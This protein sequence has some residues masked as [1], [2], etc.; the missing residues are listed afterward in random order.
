GHTPTWPTNTTTHT[1]LPTYPFQHHT[2]WLHHT[3][4]TEQTE[5]SDLGE[6][7]FWD[8]VEREDAEILSRTLGLVDSDGG[9]ALGTALPAL[10]QW[11][12]RQRELSAV[13][14]L[15][16]GV[17]W[18][19]ASAGDTSGLRGA[20]L[21]V[22]P[23][24]LPDPEV[25]TALAQVLTQGGAVVRLVTVQPH[26]EAFGPV[27]DALHDGARPAGILSL[28]ALDERPD[29]YHG[30][31]TSGTVATIGLVRV[32]AEHSVPAPLWC[33]TSGAVATGRSDPL[34]SDA[35]AQVWGLG[36]AVALEGPI[37][38]GGLVD[39]PERL[40]VRTLQRLTAVLANAGD[41]AE[42]GS[43]ETPTQGGHR[44]GGEDQIALR[45][46]GLFVRRLVRRPAAER[47]V[48]GGTPGW[49][50]RGTVL[51]TGGTG[52][53]GGHVAR[54]LAALGAEH[55]LLVGRRGAEA[56]GAEA[57]RDELVAIGAKVTVTACDVA[58]RAEVERLLDS[59]PAE[60]PLT[61]V[62]HTAGVGQLNPLLDTSDDEFAEV[63]RAKVAGALHLDELTHGCALDAFVLFSS[64]SGVWGTGGQA[65]Y[66]AANAQLDALAQR[67]RSR[68]LVATSVAWGPW[69]DAGMALGEAGE[70]SRRRG[71]LPLRPEL[72]LACLEQAITETSDT[73]LTVADVVWETF[74]TT[75]VSV[76]PSPFLSSIAE[77]PDV[78]D[79]AGASAVSDSTDTM[80]GQAL[81]R[82][83]GAL[84]PGERR[85]WLLAEVTR[86]VAAV[87]G[88]TGS[89]EVDADRPFKALGFDSLTAVELRGRLSAAL[90]VPL[91]A[92]MVFDHP[93]PDRLVAHLADTFT[94]DGSAMDAS[95]AL[96][97]GPG[98]DTDPI[99]VVSMSCRFP[100]SVRGP[101]DLWELVRAGRDT[102]GDFPS[103][104]GWNLDA[105]LESA[106]DTAGSSFATSGSFL[107]DAADFD[108]EFFG[109]S[110]RE[111]L[112][113][114]PQ[115]RLLLETSWEA[116]ERA[117]IDPSS[118][119][120][121]RTG[122]FVG[123]NGQDYVSLLSGDDAGAR[124]TEGYRLTG[125]TTS[126]VSGRISYTFGLEGPAV[127]VDTACSSSLVALHL[128]T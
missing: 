44:C 84:P 25:S 79:T 122:V 51:I 11:R 74:Y 40:D 58:D 78:G 81:R 61:A 103:D 116:F 67:R 60:V 54:R 99:A 24:E 5:I 117:G 113:M 69:A 13:D 80:P 53:L 71:L 34:R 121:S 68:G 94:A 95:E 83:L 23:A 14:S 28:L 47:R 98:D 6:A 30:P 97:S 92:T 59:V 50:P 120:G 63:V 8:A 15:R 18:V 77:V 118:L 73:S 100:G 48:T 123:G 89:G 110:P 86:E 52:A 29:A 70:H 87:L 91:P 55:L 35:Q 104:R 105:L 17:E 12:R 64:V 127:T 72:A 31:L 1:P 115:Q 33:V 107:Y 126:V 56:P 112:A 102:T 124:S 4:T 82:R 27:T 22:M 96:K 21:L 128:A 109:I 45:R 37:V 101:E 85:S 41:V 7:Q 43:A 114:D 39:L 76:R 66:G 20:W 62:V 125:N 111:A 106:P 108:A 75:F 119:R 42:P 49:K 26:D 57:L 46:S 19:P 93:T 32:L 36:R 16:Y 10:A 38:W 2:Y 65:A 90:G 88:Y 9:D 3:P